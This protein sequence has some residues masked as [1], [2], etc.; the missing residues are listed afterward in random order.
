MDRGEALYEENYRRD[1]EGRNSM[2]DWPTSSPSTTVSRASAAR[3]PH[4]IASNTHVQRSSTSSH[5]EENMIQSS[6]STN[7]RIRNTS[8][9]ANTSTP[10]ASPATA[11]QYKKPSGCGAPA[12]S[13]SQLSRELLALISATT[14]NIGRTAAC[15]NHLLIQKNVR[16]TNEQDGECWVSAGGSG[17][18]LLGVLN[19]W[20][21]D[22]AW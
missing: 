7:S 9:R 8:L 16:V 22:G 10:K 17:F 15:S 11:H 12:V 2:R 4:S 14:L 19:V 1:V 20:A 13:S 3:R 18:V 21:Y 5:R 6:L